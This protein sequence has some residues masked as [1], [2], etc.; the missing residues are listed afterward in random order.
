[1]RKVKLKKKEILALLEKR[2]G[3]AWEVMKCFERKGG[4]KSA[5]Y[6][7]ALASWSAL[8]SFKMELTD[9]VEE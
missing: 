5:A 3:E 1:M 6:N 2:E 7:E 4:D 8:Y 9:F